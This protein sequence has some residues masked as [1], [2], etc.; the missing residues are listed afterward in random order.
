MKLRSLIYIKYIGIF[1]KLNVHLIKNIFEKVP[2]PQR[3]ARCVLKYAVQE[4]GL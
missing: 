1:K 3:A 4:S 2:L